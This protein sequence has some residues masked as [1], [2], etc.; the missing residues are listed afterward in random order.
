MARVEAVVAVSESFSETL[1]VQ[2][3]VPTLNAERTLEK[4]LTRILSLD[5]PNFDVVVI[6]GKSRDGTLEI[7][8]KLGV[9]VV[10]GDFN[11][12]EAYNYALKRFNAEY[13][14]FVDA[15]CVVPQGWLSLLLGH[16]NDENVGVAGGFY[17]TPEDVGLW[18]R[19]VGFELDTRR[20]RFQ[21]Q[22]TRLPT[23]CLLIKREALEKVPFHNGFDTAQETDWG[24]RL[25][26]AGYT[27]L[28]IPEADVLHYHRNSPIAFFKQQYRYGK[29]I[30]DFYLANRKAIK[31]DEITSVYM[32]I[33]PL[34]FLTGLLVPCLLIY[35]ILLSLYKYTQ[36]HNKLALGLFAVYFLRCLA[37]STG[38]ITW[39]F[40]KLRK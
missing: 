33:Q 14:A 40:R 6:D 24:Y 11:R 36:T 35:W 27:M 26:G 17:R 9:N 19:L 20:R 8:K 15:D 22:I 32:N 4:C 25:A 5:Y 30:I 2:V 34:L 39:L 29:G 18:A 10:Q 38:L 13:F 37:W 3:V 12:S 21:R 31:G 16:M 23:G 7:C 28:Y 1:K